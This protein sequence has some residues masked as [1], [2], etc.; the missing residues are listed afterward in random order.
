[1]PFS[2][3]ALQTDNGSEFLRHFDSATEEMLVTHFFSHPYCPKDN[4]FVERKI[5]TDKYEVWAFREGYTVGELNE[6]LDEWNYTYNY[7]R[8]HQS[9]GYL[10]PMEFLNSWMEACKDRVSLSTM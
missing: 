1:M 8:P 6:V 9:L 7:M 3:L 4:A 10:T 2:L 5:Q